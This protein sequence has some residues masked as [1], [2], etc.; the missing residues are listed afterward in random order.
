MALSRTALIRCL[1]RHGFAALCLD[2]G[3]EVSLVATSA[4]GRLFGPYLGEDDL[5]GWTPSPDAFER[6]L[7]CRDW[8][9]G[10]ERIW[11]APERVFNFADPTAMLDTY[12]VDPS[13]DP[14]RWSLARDRG[15]LLL[16]ASMVVPR[17]DGGAPV[18]L[19]VRRRI[20][21][22]RNSGP[23]AP[24]CLACG[25][26]QT[27][28]TSGASGSGDP[29]V[30]PWLIRQVP[31]GGVARLSGSGEGRG[32]AVF[33]KAPAEAIIAQG[34]GWRVGFG[35][36]GFFKTSYDR[37]ALGAGGLSY[38]VPRPGTLSCLT[39]LPTLAEPALYPE[40]LA[41]DATGPGQGAALFRDEGRFGTYGEVELYG[42][43]AGT[44]R[45]RLTV[46]TR[47]LHGPAEAVSAN[48]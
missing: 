16:A 42:H 32:R 3:P 33:G 22:T 18:G 24:G 34:V 5:T 46:E 17:S 26:G 47:L 29:P 23:T 9:L 45:G 35:A 19:T 28:T 10:G 14:G 48:A 37:A 38:A 43:R 41:D 39:L 2:I 7:A 12:R 1:E 40:T 36:K 8:N 30:V 15:G 27:I 4:G 44:G 31:L 13:L 11:L 21:P 20:K 6:T 25:Y